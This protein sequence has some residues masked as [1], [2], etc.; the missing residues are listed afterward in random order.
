[1]RFNFYIY[2]NQCSI[3]NTTYYNIIIIYEYLSIYDI[4]YDEYWIESMNKKG[5]IY[6]FKY[7]FIYIF[8]YIYI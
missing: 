6:L 2:K 7:I 8:I 4:Y 5:F 1:M 3:K